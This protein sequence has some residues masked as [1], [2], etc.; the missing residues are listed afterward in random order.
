MKV[1]HLLDARKRLQFCRGDGRL[2]DVPKDLQFDPID[3]LREPVGKPRKSKAR[4]LVNVVLPGRER[5]L[6]R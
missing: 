6:H 4:E 1:R 3:L 2:L 5:F